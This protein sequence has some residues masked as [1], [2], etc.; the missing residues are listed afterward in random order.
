MTGRLNGHVSV[1]TGAA[2]G[3]GRAV[4]ARYLDEGARVVAVDID[5][6]V[7][8]LAGPTI[9]AVVGDVTDPTTNNSAVATALDRFGHIDS[10][11]AN[12]G[13]FDYFRSFE[14]LSA[15]EFHDG[16][17]ALMSVNVEAPLLLARSAMPA[18][19]TSN[20]AIV[21]TLSFAALHA[22][23]GGVLYTATKHALLGAM[24]QLAAEVAPHVRVN[25]VAP[26]GT[27]TGLRGIEELGMETRRLDA[28]PTLDASV[29]ADNP[30]GLLAEP[31][32]HCSIYVLLA[33]RAESR[34]MTGSV[35][36]SDAGFDVRGR[37]R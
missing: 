9:A 36:S 25:G 29:S 26:G 10:V 31:E 35:I 1:V 14:K 3:I 21:F 19:R 2:S 17:H 32:D 37:H 30:L 18:L 23:G 33:S 34:A 13:R 6:A 4:V 15:S 27:R 20:G 22:N 24:R 16:F 11:V 5:P 7:A 8:A 28:S 12:S